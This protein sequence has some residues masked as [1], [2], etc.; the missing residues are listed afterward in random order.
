VHVSRS[1]FI[2][3]ELRKIDAKKDREKFKL[4]PAMQRNE[5][6]IMCQLAT[7]LRLLPRTNTR[8]E[9]QETMVS[10]RPWEIQRRKPWQDDVDDEPSPAA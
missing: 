6:N 1:R 4:W 3:A 10:S 2:A 8:A 9:R 5:T 7:K